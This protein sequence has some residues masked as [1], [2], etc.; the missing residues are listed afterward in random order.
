MHIP[1]SYCTYSPTSRLL[2]LMG[3][4]LLTPLA[5]GQESSNMGSEAVVVEP[6]PL[7]TTDELN[8]LVAPVALYPD[9]LLAIVLPA[10]TYPLQVVAA[11]R[12]RADSHNDAQEPNEDW[13]ESIVALLNYPEALALLN[14]DIDWTWEL[15]LAISDQESDVMRAIQY[16]RQ[17]AYATGN[18]DSDEK[19]NVYVKD[20]SV[21]IEPADDEVMY[22]PYYEPEE[23]LQHQSTRVYHYY[24]T[25]YPV[26]YYPY[27]NDHDFYNYGFWGISSFYTLNWGNHHLR[28][29]RQNH[30]NHRYYGHRYHDRHYRYTRHYLGTPVLHRRWAHRRAHNYAY[31]GHWRPKHHRYGSRPKHHR[32]KP[33]HKRRHFDR[34]G[35]HHYAAIDQ[36]RSALRPANLDRRRSDRER[37]HTQR[38]RDRAL[39]QG[40]RDINGQRPTITRDIRSERQ[41]SQRTNPQ[42][43]EQRRIERRQQGSSK[44]GQQMRQRSQPPHQNHARPNRRDQVARNS[45]THSARQRS[46]TNTQI[47]RSGAQRERGR[48]LRTSA[49]TRLQS[50]GSSASRERRT[51]SKLQRPRAAANRSPSRSVNRQ[52]RVQQPRRQARQTR[53]DNN[54]SR[55]AEA[56]DRRGDVHRASIG[57]HGERRATSY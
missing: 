49:R 1:S 46:Q 4:F 19:Q 25:R 32:N 27:Q 56:R 24:P 34:R 57:N 47:S 20:N 41:A 51:V 23:V 7:L 45:Q 48:D 17:G 15:G 29:Y 3:M 2:L 8:K 28:H 55:R 26:Y 35:R 36:N 39:Q 37:R 22:V 14:D 40:V 42:R 30:H 33:Q 5:T 10:S 52:Q 43:T 53:K 50:L 12:F 54:R 31:N 9:D 11:A 44:K 21:I 38:Q 16:V 13:D 6:A 18:I